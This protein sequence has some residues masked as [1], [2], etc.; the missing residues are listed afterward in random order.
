MRAHLAWL[1]LLAVGLLVQTTFLPPLLSDGWRPDITRALVVWLALTGV[2]R[3]GP[4][5]AFI[6]GFFVDMASGAPPGLTATCRLALYGLARPGRGILEHGALVFL[7]GPL[8][9][10]LDG[11]VVW[12]LKSLAFANP[13]LMLVIERDLGLVDA[14]VR[15]DDGDVLRGDRL[16]VQCAR[17]RRKT[18]GIA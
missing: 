9:A 6:A 13:T 15:S 17:C 7:L 5:Y 14:G 11:F 8:A 4:W 16:A 1:G 12:L 3:G 2:P 10:L 18:A